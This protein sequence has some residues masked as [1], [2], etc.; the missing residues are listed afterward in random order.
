MKIIKLV[1]ICHFGLEAVSKREIEDLGYNV[2]EVSDGRIVYEAD[3]DGLMRSNIFLRTV[4]RVMILLDE[5]FATTFEELFDK[6]YKIIW[7]NYIP[8]NGKFPITK[9]TSVKSELF[10]TRDIQSICKKAIAVRLSKYYTRVS[11]P[12]DGPT[13]PIR[14]SILK[15]KVSVLLD[16]SGESLHKRGYRT[17]VS[18]APLSETLAASLIMLTPYNAERIL[19]DPFC[20]SGTIPIEAAMIA[21]NIA[22]G[23]KRK[24]ISMDWNNLMSS[25]DW[26]LTREE[27]FDEIKDN[28]EIDIQAYDIDY[29]ILKSAR[30]NAKSAGV[31]DVIHFQERDIKDFSSRKKYGFFVSNPPYGIRLENEED[32]KFIY[33]C[34]GDIINEY[35]TW[36]FYILSGHPDAQKIIGKRATKNRKIYNGMLKTYLYQYIGKKP[37]KDERNNNSN[38]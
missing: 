38:I 32:I 26:I 7:E 34:L 37:V 29:K 10:S 16:S 2:L 13:Y 24:F 5:F 30:N 15:N 6:I 14:I 17:Q 33:G 1:A 11:M 8:E 3:F 20:G 9:A 23:I 22:P 21:K 18:K 4:E 27:A 12:E 28:K 35:D 31:E 19:I 25:K 36:S